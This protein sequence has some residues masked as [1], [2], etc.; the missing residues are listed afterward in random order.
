[1][2]LSPGGVIRVPVPEETGVLRKEICSYMSPALSSLQHHRSDVKL[3]PFR[4]PL[5]AVGNLLEERGC[6]V[7]QPGY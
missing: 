2:F 6:L 7:S 4:K 3:S 1:M 5:E